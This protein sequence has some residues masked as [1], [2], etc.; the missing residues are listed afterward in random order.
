M[1]YKIT[2]ACVNCGACES[3][4]PVSAISEKDGARAIDA[5]ACIDCGTCASTC[6]TE[7]IVSE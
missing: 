7:A 1:A 4:C 6:P 5:G 3:E 2:D